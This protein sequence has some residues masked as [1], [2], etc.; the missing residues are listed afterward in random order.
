MGYITKNN[1]FSTLAGSISATELAIAVGAG[2][3]DRFPVIVAPDYSYITFENAAGNIEIVK[4]TA[5][6]AASDVLSIFRPNRRP[7]ATRAATAPTLPP[8]LA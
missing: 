2:H 4:L 1:A 6:A 8:T 7:V 5:R 3:G